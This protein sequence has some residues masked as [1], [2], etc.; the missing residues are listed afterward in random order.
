VRVLERFDAYVRFNENQSTSSKVIWGGGGDILSQA[1]L[2]FLGAADEG[3]FI[4]TCN[5][6]QLPIHLRGVTY[7]YFLNIHMD[8]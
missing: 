1:Y 8:R 4:Y 3:V 2:S 7:I 6:I 5:E